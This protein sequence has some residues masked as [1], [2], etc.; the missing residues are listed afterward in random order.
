MCGHGTIGIIT[1]ALE[2]SLIRPRKP[3]ELDV[4]TPAGLLRDHL[5]AARRSR[6]ISVRIRNVPSY[7]AARDL[8]LEIAGF[9]SARAWT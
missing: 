1:F 4:E 5:H 2:N 9:G 8:E 3:G 6:V 7:L